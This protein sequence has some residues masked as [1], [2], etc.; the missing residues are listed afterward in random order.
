MNIIPEALLFVIISLLGQ[1]LYF[2]FLRKHGAWL[3]WTI[4]IEGMV[5]SLAL[6]FIAEILFWVGWIVM[7][8]GI[9]LTLYVLL[10]KTFLPKL[11]NKVLYHPKLHKL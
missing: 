1:V 6:G 8:I 9:S 7:V 4:A 10:E 5:F 3:G 2:L 11:A